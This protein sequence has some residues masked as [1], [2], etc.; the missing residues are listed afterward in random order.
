M[1]TYTVKTNFCFTGKFFVKAESEKEANNMV[2]ND[3]GFVMGRGIHTGQPEDVVDWDF[4]IHPDK[5]I[6]NIKL[7][8]EYKNGNK[9]KR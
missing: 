9:R 8:K 5:K 3:C 1:K 2:K 6:L 4:P 7:Y